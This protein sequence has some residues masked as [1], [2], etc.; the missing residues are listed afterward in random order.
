MHEETFTGLSRPEARGQCGV[1]GILCRLGVARDGQGDG[2][3]CAALQIVRDEIER[4]G[5]ERTKAELLAAQ[6][7]RGCK[8]TRNRDVLSCAFRHVAGEESNCRAQVCL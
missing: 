6:P 4:E 5:R 8:E 7:K 2:V 3:L 1:Y